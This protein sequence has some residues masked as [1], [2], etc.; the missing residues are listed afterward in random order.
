MQLALRPYVTPGVAIAGAALIAVNG[1]VPAAVSRPPAEVLHALHSVERRNVQLTSG[2]DFFGPYVELF[3]NTA[4]NLLAIG[5]DNGWLSLLEQ[6]ITDPSS[7][8]RLPEVFDF[9]TQ[10]MPSISGSDPITV[11]LSPILTIGLGVIGPMVTVNDTLQDILDQIFRPTDPLDPFAAIFTAVPRLLDAYLNGVSDISAAG[12]HVPAFNGILVP[13]HNLE[14]DL[15]TSDLVDGLKIGTMTVAHLLDQTGIGTLSAAGA[16]TGLLDTLDLG[17]KTPVD[18]LDAIGLG[19]LKTASVL[20]TVVDAL[21]IGNPTVAEI[22]DRV[23]IGNDQLADLAIDVTHALGFN[24]P[25]VTDITS[26]IGL[27][28]LKL[29]DLGVDVLNSLGLGDPTISGLVT[30]VGAGDLTVQGLVTTVVDAMG[31]GGQ[32]PLTLL[33]AAGGGDLTTH[34][35]LTSLLDGL[36][37][38]NQSLSDLLSEAGLSDADAGQLIADVLGPAGNKTVEQVL[39]YAGFGNVTV[40]NVTDLLG[41]TNLSLGT[42]FGNLHTQGVIGN[43]TINDFIVATGGTALAKGGDTDLISSLS[44]QTIGSILDGQHM[45]NAPISSLLGETGTSTLNQ[46]IETNFSMTL[47]ELLHQAGMGDTTLNQLVLANIPDQPL[48]A[49]LGAAGN[50]TLDSLITQLIPGHQTLVDVLNQAGIGDQH[51]SDLLHQVLG[52][53]TVNTALDDSGLGS[54]HLDDII[55]QALGTKTLNDALNQF[56]IGGQSL[57]DLFNQFLGEVTLHDNAISLGLGDHTLDELVQSLL[58]SATVSSLLGDFGSQTIDH[59]LTS[60]NIAD[61]SVI[62]TDIEDFVGSLAYFIDGLPSQ[63]AAVLGG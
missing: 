37:L 48:S 5:Q 46:L 17:H 3:T 52:N 39:D 31:L 54:M 42:I 4:N 55:R 35:V 9:L 38:G 18:V 34:E 53:E 16:V 30:Q 57:G 51:L 21:G 50:T 43:L 11:L 7:L 62:H 47:G 40:K 27:G 44:G 22:M 1:A 32:T 6:I 13:S 28:D 24:N 8:S 23:G 61:L 63:I 56:G 29:A 36:G 14:L 45:L 10:L 33:D 58:G 25:V 60:L 20:T 49:L 41:I 12:I 19:D 59:L 2:T 15:T 26:D